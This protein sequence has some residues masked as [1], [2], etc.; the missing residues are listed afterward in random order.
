MRRKVAMFWQS[1]L[2]SAVAPSP[3]WTKP[4]MR[5]LDEQSL[6]G[7]FQNV[8]SD[9]QYRLQQIKRLVSL[10]TPLVTNLKCSEIFWVSLAEYRHRSKVDSYH[11]SV[12]ALQAER[13]CPTPLSQ[14][15]KLGKRHLVVFIKNIQLSLRPTH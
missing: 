4:G 9:S 12:S 10:R 14:E 15:N 1:G 13:V 5:E 11:M 6:R 2:A 8:A 3:V 7:S